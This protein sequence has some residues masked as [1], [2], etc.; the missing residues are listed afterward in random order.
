[1]GYV[2]K[3]KK[4]EKIL[5]ERTFMLYDLFMSRYK[6]TKCYEK[7]LNIRHDYLQ[8]VSHR[9]IDENQV[10]IIEYLQ[11]KNMIKKHKLV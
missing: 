7:I 11:I 9:I 5:C 3:N 8:K 1:M 2:I 10:I 4:W 6:L